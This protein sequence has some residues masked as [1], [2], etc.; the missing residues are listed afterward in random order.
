M[1]KI[2]HLFVLLAS[3]F[4][5]PFFAYS[6]DEGKFSTGVLTEIEKQFPGSKIVDVSAISELDSKLKIAIESGNKEEETRLRKQINEFYNES[7]I[8]TNPEDRDY[9]SDENIGAF[10]QPEWLTNDVLVYEGD[11]G[12]SN[13]DHRR[14][15]LK[16]GE[17]GNLYAALIRRPVTGT[18][19]NI[20]VY[21][22]TN[23][24]AT[25]A[26]VVS[27]SS[28]T[29][30]FGQIS[31]TVETRSAGNM[32]STR[33]F[34]F[35]SRS[36][37]LDFSNATINYFSVLRDGTGYK[38]GTSVLVPPTG[39]KLLYPSAVSDGQYWTT[40]TYIGVTC[41]EFDASNKMQNLHFAR[42]SNWG[43]NYNSAVINDAYPS[44]EDWFP[45]SAFKK[46]ISA[47]SVYIAVERRF[48]GGTS[49]IRIIATPWAP[50]NGYH[51]KYV[52]DEGNYV[53]PAITIIQDDSSFPKRIVVAY[54]K[55]K[56]AMYNYSTDGGKNWSADNY[57][58]LPNEKASYI[59]ISSDSNATSSDY[60]VAAYQLESGDSIV[61][62]RG[63]PGNLG[64]RVYKANE[65]HSSI[66]NAPVVAVYNPS[67]T[68][69]SALLYTGINSNY[70][71]N[72]YFDGEHL[73]T[74]INQE[75]G[76]PEIY[77]LDQNYPN[78]FNPS[79]AI[80]FSIPEQTF[81]TLKVFNSIGQEVA[82]LLNRE[83]AAG[84]HQVDFNANTLSSGIYFYQIS[85]ANFT[86]TKKMILIK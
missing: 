43:D 7:K 25:W 1:K 63:F 36:P 31:M 42:T 9:P 60:V 32:D 11:I 4:I 72:V 56:L 54:I 38:G 22:S 59:A 17:D 69:S 57:V 27:V 46:D 44:W 86:A 3:F 6:Q 35:Y 78:P 61:V 66:Y 74:G 12:Q 16:M 30:Y 71:N 70:T 84:N 83:V 24:G 58:G 49:G 62:R 67:G 53:K 79:T 75:S 37:N 10:R 13:T 28:A 23:G 52:G 18:N 26:S 81:V 15:D 20:S 47:D 8:I 55:D 68:K 34:V 85:S 29:A 64:S 51:R 5:L 80:K 48:S 14:I 41:A 2:T 40:A 82:T 33:I 65:F 77:S 19:G 45:V 21:K 50:S 73:I 39:N 76:I